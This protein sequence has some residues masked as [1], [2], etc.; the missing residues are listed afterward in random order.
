MSESEIKRLKA[1]GKR[2]YV[3]MASLILG[4]L[5]IHFAYN[6]QIGDPRVLGASTKVEPS[7][8]LASGNE[9]R[10]AHGRQELKESQLLN[11]AAQ[12]K[13]N[14]MIAKNY[15]DH[16]SPDNKAPWDFMKMAGYKYQSA[17]ENLA[18]G[19]ATGE[20]VNQAWITSDEHRANLLGDF[21]EVGYAIAKSDN[22]QGE[23]NTVVVAMYAN[24]KTVNKQGVALAAKTNSLSNTSQWVNGFAV[25]LSGNATWATYA[26]FGLIGAALM[27][28]LVTH[29]E[30]LR[31]GWHRGKHYLVLHP[32]LDTIIMLAIALAL[33]YAASGFIR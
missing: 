21:S 8:L 19:F 10:L 3:W 18:Y 31:L 4:I 25:V 22:F 30:T 16:H 29:L 14:D 5:A 27:G 28:F 9:Y 26:S 2:R 1:L 15:W 23:Q 17:G 33:V 24:P 7:V 20:E 11:R 13:A 32:I 12:L 6:C